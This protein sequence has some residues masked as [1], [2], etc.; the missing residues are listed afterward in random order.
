MFLRHNILAWRIEY[1]L[2][3]VKGPEHLDRSDRQP[4]QHDIAKTVSSD[5]GFVNAIRKWVNSKVEESKFPTK[6][7]LGY[8]STKGIYGGKLARD[9]EGRL[10]FDVRGFVSRIDQWGDRFLRAY[11]EHHARDPISM[12]LHKPKAFLKL[13]PFVVDAKR[14]RGTPEQIMP[15][16]Q[17]FGLDDMY[18]LHPW[19]I[20]IKQPEVFTHSIGLQDIF[21]ADLINHPTLTDIDRF[22]SLASTA[23]YIGELHKRD[24]CIAEGVVNSFL[25]ARH[26]GNKVYEPYLMLPTEMY[27]PEKNI[28]IIEQKTT[29]ILDLFVTAAYEEL[30][31][32]GSWESVDH[33]IDTILT[34]YGDRET[35]AVTISFIKRG[36]VT[37]PND[38]AALPFETT[39]SYRAM[40][41]IAA[42]HNTQRLM[43]NAEYAA[44]VRRHIQSRCEDFLK[45]TPDITPQA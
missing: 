29:D 44:D 31:R 5:H 24:V 40:R 22:E 14:Y 13:L 39:A 6:E 11:D 33:A 3:M 10:V 35:I 27:N 17:K 16:I 43:V 34:A 28:S 8:E 20:E 9:G 23:R 21:R 1:T 18:G 26:E 36:R 42:L 32:S 41:P 12:A 45:R 37:L 4:D 7:T 19:G 2:L 30:R 15:Q 25:F 38:I